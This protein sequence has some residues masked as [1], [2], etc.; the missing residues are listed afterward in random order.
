M[1]A[2]VPYLT[3]PVSIALLNAVIS[4]IFFTYPTSPEK[5]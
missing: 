5:R 1:I 3:S 4:P 2:S